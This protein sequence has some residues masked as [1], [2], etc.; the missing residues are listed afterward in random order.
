M[1]PSK[2]IDPL[3]SE[4]ELSEADYLLRVE[5]VKWYMYYRNPY[6]ACL[7]LG[8]IDPYA[9]DWA[10]AFMKEG[11]VRR[12]IQKAEQEEDTDKSQEI[13]KKNYRAWMEREATYYGPGS[14]HGSRV[15]AIA[16]LMKMEGMNAPEKTEAEVEFKG[17][18]MVVPALQSPDEWGKRAA[19]TQADLKRSVKD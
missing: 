6:D 17:G 3:L 13:R 18:V 8:F 9:E 12:L 7:K 16:H 19:Q 15:A 11:V 2:Y 14:Q 4:K 5:F 1:G 10:R